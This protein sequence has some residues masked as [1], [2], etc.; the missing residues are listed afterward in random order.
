MTAPTAPS[1]ER[2]EQAFDYE[3]EQHQD[4]NTVCT[5]KS[6]HEVATHLPQLVPC[7]HSQDAGC[8]AHAQHAVDKWMPFVE[9]GMTDC[10]VCD[11][12]VTDITVRPI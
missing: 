8:L 1:Q 6:C 10:T 3:L 7:G 9:R 12:T 5:H 11:T 4:D 2:V